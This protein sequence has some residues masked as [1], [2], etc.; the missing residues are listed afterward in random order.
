MT[1]P[2]LEEASARHAPPRPGATD[3]GRDL[4]PLRRRWDVVV[5]T[6]ALVLVGVS[7]PLAAGATTATVV[8]LGLAPV[9]AGALPRCRGT[10]A[11]VALTV[12]ALP[13]GLFLAEVVGPPQGRQWDPDGA[14]AVGLLL[15][16]AVGA[17]GLAVWAR[18]VLPTRQVAVLVGSG[19]LV[20]GLLDTP[21]S[22]NAWKYNL[23]FPVTLVV[24]AVLAR[25]SPRVACVA[26]LGLAVIGITN[27]SRS[28]AAFCLLAAALVVWRSAATGRSSRLR[29]LGVVGAAGLTA[30]Q[31]GVDL[32]VQGYLGEAL[33]QRSVMQVQNAG[34]LIAGGRPEWAA[35]RELFAAHPWGFGLGAVP[36]SDDLR[37]AKAG[38]AT[39]GISGDNGYVNNYM[40]GGG[41]KLH[42]IVADL[43]AGF[44]VVGIALGLLLVALVVRAMASSLAGRPSPLVVFLCLMALWWLLFGPIQS[45]LLD[46]AVVLGLAAPLEG[47]DDGP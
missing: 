19:L 38:L 17:V 6:V 16:T 44:G 28:Y 5:A 39:V 25:R 35:T 12:A 21:G 18:T 47:S 41:F 34:S 32:L 13:F 9:W 20:D 33:Q 29:V 43:W 45:N 2:Q 10:V 1:A 24:L 40:F 30:Y 22:L 14:T 46:V 4:D 31:L 42:A 8:V 7:Q 11:L 37:T 26:L 23:S 27:E 36:T 15:V 3:R